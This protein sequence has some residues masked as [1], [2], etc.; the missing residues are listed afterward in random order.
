MLETMKAA[1]VEAVREAG[2]PA[3]V[4]EFFDPRIS[5][6]AVAQWEICP[7]ERVITLSRGIDWKITPHRLRPDLYPHPDDGLPLERRGAMAA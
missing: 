5:R 6:A 1:L 4:G 2:G 7:G 3:K